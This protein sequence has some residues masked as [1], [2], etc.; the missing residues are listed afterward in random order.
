MQTLLSAN[1]SARAI[2]VIFKDGGFNNMNITKQLSPAQNTPAVQATLGY[3]KPFDPKLI[4]HR[5]VV[6]QISLSYTLP[7]PKTKGV[8]QC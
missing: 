6:A 8:I 7:Y 3:E 2:L 4:D 5:Y 1:Q